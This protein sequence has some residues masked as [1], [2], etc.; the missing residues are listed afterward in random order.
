M[1]HRLEISMNKGKDFIQVG[2]NKKNDA[3]QD[4]NDPS[5][6]IK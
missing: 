5:K 4:V 2:D 3:G 1:I 6:M